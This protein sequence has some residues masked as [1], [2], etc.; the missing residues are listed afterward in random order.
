M[1]SASGEFMIN[2]SQSKSESKDAA[3]IF[4]LLFELYID[5]RISWSMLK[6]IR[7]ISSGRATRAAIDASIPLSQDI[8]ASRREY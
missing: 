2:A 6:S 8:T 3:L 7:F 1:L 4:V 5:D